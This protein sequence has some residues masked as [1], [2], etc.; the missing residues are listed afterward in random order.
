MRL[1]ASED[2]DQLEVL[3][4]VKATAARH[5]VYLKRFMRADDVANP[6]GWPMLLGDIESTAAGG[7]L[8]RQQA[9]ELER[10]R[11]VLANPVAGEAA[12]EEWQAIVQIV[13]ELVESG[14]PPSNREIREALLSVIEGL[15]ERMTGLMD[16]RR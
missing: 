7:Q 1:G 5:H 10:L 11:G 8:S 14:V 9:V 6:S 3:E 2:S 13:S 15:P 12:T 4:W 16:L